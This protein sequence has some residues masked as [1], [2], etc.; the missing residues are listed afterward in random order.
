MQRQLLMRVHGV[1]SADEALWL[2]A[3]GV[4]LVSV[5]V[6]EP[7]EGRGISDDTA[8]QIADRLTSARLCV[9]PRTEAELSLAEIRRMKAAY[10]AVPW[11]RDVSRAW[12]EEL[13]P[14]GLGWARVR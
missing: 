12:R 6:G 13:A 1:A 7:A 9:E 5:V 11:G 10:V 3:L 14:L 2:E 4:G 8:R